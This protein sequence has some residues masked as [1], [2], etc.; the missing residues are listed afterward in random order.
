MYDKLPVSSIHWF[1]EAG[2]F[3]ASSNK[4]SI[5]HPSYMILSILLDLNTPAWT[6]QKENP[7]NNLQ[8]FINAVLLS[9]PDSIVRIVNSRKIIFD[10]QIHRSF[11]RVFEFVNEMQSIGILN[12]N[13]SGLTN[14]LNNNINSINSL[15]NCKI[16][17]KD[18]GFTLMELPT[19]ILIFEMS[20]CD[21]NPNNNN[22]LEYLKCMFV[23]QNREIPIYA[24]SLHKNSFIKMCC[25]GSGGWLLE[26]YSLRELFGILGN[27]VKRKMTYLMRCSCCDK[28]VTVG[29]VC[30]VCLSIFCRFMPVCKKCKTKF[31]FIK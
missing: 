15:N 24:F 11:T 26:D 9:N 30:P 16:T 1:R 5:Q 13:I 3:L 27:P 2:W 8:V 21:S 25:E 23:A 20:K 19:A 28:A 10:S 6:I 29:L 12:S 17:P 31:N 7:L 22:Y 18:L 4:I 14:N